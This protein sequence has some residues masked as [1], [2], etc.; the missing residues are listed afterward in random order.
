MNLRRF[1]EI[2]R[3]ETSYKDTVQTASDWLTLLL[4]RAPAAAQAQQAM[5]EHPHDHAHHHERIYTLIDFNDAFVS[6]VLLLSDTQRND[7]VERLRQAI[8][9]CCH[10]VSMPT[11]S[12]EQFEA[13]VHGLSREIAVYE[14]AARHGLQPEMTPRSA[15]A[16][17]VDMVIYNPKSDKHINVDCKTRSSFHFRLKDLMHQGRVS[18]SEVERAEADGYIEVVHRGDGNVRAK[19]ILLRVSQDDFGEVS[20]FR[21]VSETALTTRLYAIVSAYGTHNRERY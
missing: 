4:L 13:I 11:F 8:D 9:E 14:A 6:T 5:D 2:A 12:D 16:F 19:I 17:G 1:D 20:S 7:F 18:P 15:D 3:A 21:F 10:S